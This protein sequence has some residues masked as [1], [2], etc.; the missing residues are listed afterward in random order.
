MN[1]ITIPVKETHLNSQA[2]NAEKAVTA[3]LSQMATQ[4]GRDVQKQALDFITVILSGGRV[5]SCLLFPW[6]FVRYEHTQAVRARL[7]DV[8]KP[9]TVNRFISALRGVL[10]AA[11][12]VGLMSAEA[13]QRAADIKCV[14]GT[15]LPAGREISTSELSLIFTTC[16]ADKSTAG[17]RD[18][19]L[20][21]L[22]YGGGLRRDEL[23]KM[24]LSDIEADAGRAMVKGKGNKER[25]AY[26]PDG[27]VSALL[28]WMKLR[29]DRDGALFIRIRKSAMMCPV[30][31]YMTGQAIYTI[32]LRR[33][34]AA[35]V[36]DVSPH[37][38]RRTFVS[39]LLDNGQDLS[40]V[41][42]MAGHSSIQ[43]TIRYDRR[44]DEAKK[45]A[46]LTLTIPFMLASGGASCL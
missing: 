10:R 35:G 9:A 29:G 37:D 41:S 13:Y 23:A 15:S 44:S 12:R 7:I 46:A 30:E 26:L 43:T 19:A 6:H 22:M 36:R 2:G 5:S 42:K 1:N 38:M 17:V 25:Y 21:A 33:A 20:F 8:Y 11:W 18:F 27:A 34:A 24:S 4:R 32:L 39:N 45:R 14:K 31:N 28:A 16:A 3:Y 40:T